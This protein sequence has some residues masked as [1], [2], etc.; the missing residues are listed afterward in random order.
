MQTLSSARR[1]HMAP[2]SASECTAT[3]EIPISLQ[4]RWIRRAISPRFAMR[5][6]SN[7]VCRLLE[8][9][10]RLAE[11]DRLRVG[12]QNFQ[13]HPRARGRNRVHGLH[14]FDDQQ[15]LT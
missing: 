9:D 2:V 12:D 6:L 1:T 13:N 15:R 4:A 10:E 14:G 7:T 3:V 5:I 8:D 11:F